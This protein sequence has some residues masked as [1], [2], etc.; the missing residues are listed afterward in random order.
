VSGWSARLSARSERYDNIKSN[1]RDFAAAAPADDV[2]NLKV[3]DRV[4]VTGKGT[5]VV[6]H[7]DDNNVRV[8]M[9]NKLAL[10]MQRKKIVWCPLGFTANGGD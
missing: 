9:R 7:V 6:E 5:G 4:A 8:V 3:G 10:R 2:I 1:G